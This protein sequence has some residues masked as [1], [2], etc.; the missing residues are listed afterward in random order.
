MTTL[1]GLD[2]VFS[3]ISKRG[4]AEGKALSTK[5]T[6]NATAESKKA[7]SDSAKVAEPSKS[8]KVPDNKDGIKKE[9]KPVAGVKRPSSASGVSAPAA[10][11]ASAISTSATATGKGGLLKQPPSTST[12]AAASTTPAAAK[13]K[14][15]QVVTKPPVNFF[16][17]LQSASKKPGTSLSSAK[18]KPAPGGQEK[19]STAPAPVARS[20]FSFAETMANLTRVQEPESSKPE[21]KRP[22]ETAEEK[23]KRLR[24]EERRKLRVSWKP[25]A[26]LVEIK[27]FSRDPSEL[28]GNAT[29]VR[30]VRDGK[31]K[32]GL[33]FKQHMEM[34]DVD[35]DDDQPMEQSFFDFKTPSLIDF[36][37][38]E[39]D[40]RANNYEPYGGGEK[41]VDSPE[42]L[43]QENREANTLMV[44]YMVKSD[45]PPCPREP[46]DPYTGPHIE[47]KLFGAPD[48]PTTLQ[49]LSRFAPAPA[50]VPD[51]SALL[52]NLHSLLPQGQTQVQPPTMDPNA[53]LQNLLSNQFGL[54]TP[55][56]AQPAQ[57]AQVSAPPAQD[58]PTYDENSIEA[59]L[60]KLSAPAQQPAQPQPPAAAP[61]LQPYTSMDQNALLAALV[62]Q[63]QQN[64]YASANGVSSTPDGYDSQSDRKRG[65]DD[66][67]GGQNAGKDGNKRQKWNSKPHTG[68][69][70]IY[71]CRFYKKGECKK[72]ADCTYRHEN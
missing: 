17:G 22:P 14:G 62:N 48:D 40:V 15:H 11:R 34:Q 29:N 26:V 6:E 60:A 45:I 51:V 59:I 42:R 56:P 24:K 8:P 61:V 49:R 4:D 44:H 57:P 37:Q 33:M 58:Q 3:R 46:A 31:E 25:D 65:R 69:K 20:T 39:T 53:A 28:P 35:D 30:D 9:A 38:L 27:L 67:E 64:P 36:S 19:K 18:P 2:K 16:S 32:E 52:A 1:T 66:H 41:K 68:P 50:A 7:A 10:K 70:F 5:I 47:T 43:L 71:E 72:G 13:A 12:P 55:Q 21:V 23:A 54:G 63:T